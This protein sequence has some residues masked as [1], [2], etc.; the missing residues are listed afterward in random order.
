MRPAIRRVHLLLALTVGLFAA[1]SGLTGSVLVFHPELDRILNA[2]LRSVEPRDA[3][4]QLDAAI[5]AV[6]GHFPDEPIQF[7]RLARAPGETYEF[8]IGAGLRRVYV[9]PYT[10]RILG[11]RSE[12]PG[13][14]GFIENLHEHLLS[15]V[16][17]QTILGVVGL[18]LL[19][20]LGTG[21]Y[22][23][24]PGLRKLAGAFRLRR[25]APWIKVNYD[26][27]RLIGIVSFLL[28]FLSALTGAALIFHRVSAGLLIATLGG[29]PPPAPPVIESATPGP[30]LSAAVLVERAH[31][32][33]PDAT[34]TWIQPPAS[35]KAPFLVRLRFDSNPH[36][37]GTTYVAVHPHT[38][39]ILAL[40]SHRAAGF[41]QKA[42][43]L[44]YP[45]H[46][47]EALG[48]AGRIAM[49]AAG[50]APTALLVTGL[51]FWLIRR[52]P[53]RATKRVRQES[54]SSLA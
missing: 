36:P 45:L 38:G 2:E 17:G 31:A 52:R 43:D 39:E 14:I 34:P 21:L 40:H 1:L 9:D 26:L 42:A 10:T 11:W 46:T 8:W 44:R 7:A 47:G 16:T 50:L 28:L 22:L 23:W 35:P 51:S 25:G 5:A 29:T 48:L 3:R 24:W 18:V 4:P 41:G 15:G 27:H 49:A 32:A 33:L 6:R 20:V 13:V 19:V 37:N 30:I 54:E 12:H 53:A